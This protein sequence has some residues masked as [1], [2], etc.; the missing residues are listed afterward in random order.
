M[1]LLLRLNL[2]PAGEAPTQPAYVEEWFV[3]DAPDRVF[4][5]AAPDR[6]F[7]VPPRT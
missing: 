5:V 2:D 3:V 7:V 1:L 4:V 6:T